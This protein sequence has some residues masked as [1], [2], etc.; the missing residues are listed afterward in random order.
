MVGQKNPWVE[1]P[2]LES[3]ALSR[4]AGCRVFLKLETLQPS[5]S[6]KSRG[7]GHYLQR[8]LIRS[9]SRDTVHF[10]SSSGGNAGL[11]CVYAARVLGRPATVVVPLSTSAFMIAKLRAAGAA[12]VLQFGESWSEADAYL[13]EV[14][15][16]EEARVGE[17][18]EEAVYVPPFDHSDIWE[19][20]AS[21]MEEVG[22]QLRREGGGD[23]PPDAVIC[24]VGG[25]G[26]FN[27]V[28][29]GLDRLGWS[30]TPVLAVET[31]GAESLGAS[32]RHGK[33][34]TLPGITS[35]AKSLGA[36]RV[37]DRAYEN[38][39]RASVTS[40]VLSDAEAAMGCWRLADDERMLVEMACGVNVALCYDGRL[41]KVL[42]RRLTKESRVVVVLCGGSN[43]TVDMVV[44][45]R[46]RFGGVERA[47]PK[48]RDVPSAETAPNGVAT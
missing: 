27:G 21:L 25:G 40:V 29:Q 20:N 5:G 10:Y 31:Q 28:M 46:T 33:H 15:M 37:C 32:L 23:E 34:V 45:W 19:G 8:A 26:L 18:V 16:R 3:T 13:R 24:S 17:K 14:V 42:G 6:F 48:M 39:Q 22:L 38:G 1:T 47:M 12:E 44:E 11:A 4:A 9:T 41:E 30:D 35:L 7:I 2:L 43:V 36:T